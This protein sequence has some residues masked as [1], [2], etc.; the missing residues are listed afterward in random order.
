MLAFEPRTSAG[1]P[2]GAAHAAIPAAAAGSAKA[3]D[4]F[5]M[6]LR[7]LGHVEGQN[8]VIEFRYAEG[9]YDRLP[10]LAGEL[11]ATGVDVLITH[12]TPGTRAARLPS[13]SSGHGAMS[14]Q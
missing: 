14:A 1:S 12:G 5:R 9:R 10:Q 8:I 6:G 3:I 4:S 13:M 11:V 2:M 7:E